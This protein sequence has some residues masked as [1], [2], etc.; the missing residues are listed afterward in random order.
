MFYRILTFFFGLFLTSLGISFFLIYV[1]LVDNQVSFFPFL[2]FLI[3]RKEI[4]LI[5]IGLFFLLIATFCD[6]FWKRFYLWR[7]KQKEKRKYN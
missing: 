7:K 6:P 1:S 3:S 5:P 4:Y 2:L